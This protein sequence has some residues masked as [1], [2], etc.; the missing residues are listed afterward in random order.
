MAGNRTNVEKVVKRFFLRITL[1]TPRREVMLH[2]Q[3]NGGGKL[4]HRLHLHR[5]VF[6]CYSIF[7]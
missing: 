4:T 7:Q 6:F 2:T 5:G 3:E 1:L